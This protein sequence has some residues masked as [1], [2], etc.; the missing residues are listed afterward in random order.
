MKKINIDVNNAGNGNYS[1]AVVNGI[2]QQS[3]NYSISQSTL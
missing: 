3:H 2:R 1:H